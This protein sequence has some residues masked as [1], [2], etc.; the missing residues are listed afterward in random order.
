MQELPDDLLE[1]VAERFRL[2]G[3]ATRLRIIR[4]LLERG[5]ASVGE[6]VAATGST[7]ANVSKHLR[8][9]HDARL[10]RRRAE[11]T[12]A[13]Y[14]VIDPSVEELCEIVCGGIRRQ[15]EHEAALVGLIPGGNQ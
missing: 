4:C 14:R 1:F 9:L 7:Q 10:V 2:L 13:F 8:L 3:D 12:M 6:I 11:G 5:E 15:V